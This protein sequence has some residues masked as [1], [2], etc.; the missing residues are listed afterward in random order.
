MSKKIATVYKTTNLVSGKIYIGKHMAPHD[1]PLNIKYLGSGV[2]IKRSILKYGKEC[3]HKEL[4]AICESEED[5]YN[6]EKTIVNSIFVSRSDTYNGTTGGAGLT[7]EE[8]KI[9]LKKRYACQEYLD[10][11]AKLMREIS[12]KPEVRNKISTALTNLQKDP[13]YLKKMREAYDCKDRSI[14][15][16]IAK[17]ENHAKNPLKAKEAAML[18]GSNGSW[19][20]NVSEANKKKSKDTKWREANLVAMRKVHATDD[21]KIAHLEGI[22]RRSEN[23]S[24]LDNVRNSAK[25]KSENLEWQEWIQA[26]NQQL[27]NNPEWRKAIID[28]HNTDEYKAAAS[29]RA[30]E[31]W[32]NPEVKATRVIAM[33]K[34]R[35]CSD[36]SKKHSEAASKAN[37]KQVVINGVKYSR[38]KDASA[39]LGISMYKLRKFLSTG[40]S[41]ATFCHNIDK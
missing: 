8:A 28:S 24:W 29:A 2:A 20:K 5:A 33:Q 34:M 30:K 10:R 19:Y 40:V 1:N 14:K 9:I 21:W 37:S 39:A 38:M 22:K 25:A 7:S 17:K 27:K 35:E 6:L 32:S 41:N 12:S 16:S 3:F 23:K 15:I 4:I 36:F 18:R 31:Q 11:H 13:A 26:H